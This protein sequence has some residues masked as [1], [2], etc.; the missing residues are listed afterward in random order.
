L[1]K[2]NSWSGSGQLEQYRSYSINRREIISVVRFGIPEFETALC[3]CQQ[4]GTIGF[5]AWALGALA[6]FEKSR[7]GDSEA[8]IIDVVSPFQLSLLIRSLVSASSG[9]KFRTVSRYIK[10]LERPCSRT[11]AGHR[12]FKEFPQSI[13]MILL[14]RELHD[15]QIFDAG[16]GFLCVSIPQ[17]TRRTI[18]YIPSRPVEPTHYFI[19]APATCLFVPLGSLASAVAAADGVGGTAITLV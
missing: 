13:S 5:A 16:D 1:H 11:W 12:S 18:Q 15:K 4:T 3:L 2:G 9:T 14:A 7:Y 8:S 10:S 19:K 17:I 6:S